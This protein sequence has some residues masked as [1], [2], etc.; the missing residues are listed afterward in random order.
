VLRLARVISSIRQLN[1]FVVRFQPE[2]ATEL[3]LVGL[4][5]PGLL[6][7]CRA[8]FWWLFVLAYS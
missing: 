3:H 4:K 1:G 5:P 7:I 6:I 8:F 2:Q